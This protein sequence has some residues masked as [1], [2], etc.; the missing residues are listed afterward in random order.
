MSVDC[1]LDTNI[2]VYAATGGGEDEPK[3]KR[4]LDL[5]EQEDFALSAQVLQEFY[6]TVT[7]KTAKTL[8][9][10]EALEWIEQLKPSRSWRS[11]RR[12]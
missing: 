9:S 2:L 8:S 1:F 11:T 3:R 10:D 7:R 4:A 5:I 6:V 12:W